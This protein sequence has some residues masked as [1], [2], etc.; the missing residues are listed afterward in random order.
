MSVRTIPEP[1][2][3]SSRRATRP[4]AT[5]CPA[6]FSASLRV[7]EA[8]VIDVSLPEIGSAPAADEAPFD[9]IPWLNQLRLRNLPALKP[10]P[11][12]REHPSRAGQ[13]LK[14]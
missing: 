1:A 2:R 12:P 8:A 11:A 14:R 10:A 3:Y 4:A 5:A 6:C 13:V 9:P 7:R